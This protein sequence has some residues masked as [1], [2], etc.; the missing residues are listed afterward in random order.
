[1]RPIK[2]PRTGSNI[3]HRSWLKFIQR[4][5][6]SHL[7]PIGASAPDLTKMLD[8]LNHHIGLIESYLQAC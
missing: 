2:D 3:L 1:M 5:K 8:F 6:E 7:K 4:G